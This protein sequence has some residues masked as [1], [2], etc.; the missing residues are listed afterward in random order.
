MAT[1]DP[2]ELCLKL[3]F[4]TGKPSPT[5]YG[6]HIRPSVAPE[7]ITPRQSVQYDMKQYMTV[8]GRTLYNSR[9]IWRSS[10]IF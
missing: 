9:A 7:S 2:V 8:G 6:S 4:G 10:E 1:Y 5:D 3:V